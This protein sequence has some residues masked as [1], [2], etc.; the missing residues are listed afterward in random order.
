VLRKPKTDLTEI[1]EIYFEN[2]TSSIAYFLHDKTL[3]MH[4]RIETIEQDFPKL[5]DWIGAKG[6]LKAAC[7]NGP[8]ATT[9]PNSPPPCPFT[10]AQIS[11][12]EASNATTKLTL[13]G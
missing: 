8:C 10:L 3:V 6:D 13:K 9:P 4:I 7:M 1:I 12:P 11:P 5:W 2:I